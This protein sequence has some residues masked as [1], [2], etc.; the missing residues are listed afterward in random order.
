MAPNICDSSIW[1][2][3][4]VTHLVPRIF[5]WLP[6]F[7]K[8]STSLKYGIANKTHTQNLYINNKFFTKKE[9]QNN[10]IPAT[11]MKN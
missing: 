4:H 6:N 1:N 5:R 10:T 3:H 8:I 9:R 7:W 11:N 2:L